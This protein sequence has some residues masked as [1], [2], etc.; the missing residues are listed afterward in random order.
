MR[1][2]VR[3]KDKYVKRGERRGKQKYK[4]WKRE[5]GDKK[6]LGVVLKSLFERLLPK[7]KGKKG[8]ENISRVWKRIKEDGIGNTKRERNRKE[9]EKVN[10]GI[11]KGKK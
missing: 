2:K 7:N 5:S 11:V 8:I 1:E 9:M 4:E 10:E 6:V 3:E